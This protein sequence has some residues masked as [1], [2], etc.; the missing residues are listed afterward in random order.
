MSQSNET[1]KN[2][3]APKKDYLEGDVDVKYKGGE[4]LNIEKPKFTNAKKNEQHFVDIDQ[5]QDLFAK[6]LNQKQNLQIEN[7]YS[8][9]K[10][11]KDGQQEP[12]G[13]RKYNKERKEYPNNN[14][15]ERVERTEKPERKEEPTVELDSDGFEIV[16]SKIE[17]PK[18]KSYNDGDRKP[19]VKRGGGRGGKFSNDRGGKF[20]P[21]NDKG[22]RFDSKFERKGPNENKEN[23]EDSDGQKDNQDQEEKEQKS[24]EPKQVKK[25]G[26]VIKVN[27][28]H[29]KLGDLF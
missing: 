24:E 1:N 10:V 16:G 28:Q 12:R 21:S 11:G 4:E 15:Q 27:P 7:V 29:K 22:G 3:K 5:S 14:N 23:K 13:E 18:K 9:P 19:Y 25:E 17:K 6:N 20:D 2:I 8:E 26:A